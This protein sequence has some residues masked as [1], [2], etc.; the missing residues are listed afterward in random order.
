TNV[1]TDLIVVI[2]HELFDKFP[3]YKGGNSNNNPICGRKIQ[4]K[5]NHS[6]VEVT[7]TDHCVGC[8]MWS[9][10]FTNAAFSKLA[11][12]DNGRLHG[13]AWHWV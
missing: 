11:D 3:G 10:D 13:V 5:Y 12:L 4:A 8:S 2:S 9:L 6:S 1:S 7:V